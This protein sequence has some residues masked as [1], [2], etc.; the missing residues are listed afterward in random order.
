[1]ESIIVGLI[2]CAAALYAVWALLPPMTR[3]KLA[4]RLAQETGSS[5]S[6]PGWWRRFV[7]R[8]ESKASAAPPDC[9][10]CGTDHG[11]KLPR[12]PPQSG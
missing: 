5:E 1:M 8:L 9:A 6:A 11:S 12:K 7:A 4:R 2:V 3:L 10:N